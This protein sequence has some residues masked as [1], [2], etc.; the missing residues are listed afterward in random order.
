MMEAVRSALLELEDAHREDRDGGYALA[1]EMCTLRSSLSESESNEWSQVLLDRVTNGSSRAWGVALEAMA[2]CGTA[3]DAAALANIVRMRNIDAAR[4][5]QIAHTLLRLHFHDE[6]LVALVAEAARARR[7]LGLPNLAA[8]LAADPTVAGLAAES[9]HAAISA[10][11]SDYMERY[12]P[13]FAYAA[14]EGG[15]S[16]IVVLVAAL[17]DIDVR[18]AG[19]FARF[20]VAY[21]KKPFV[22][23]KI[24]LEAAREIEHALAAYL[25]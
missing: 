19:L 11:G 21:L 25:Q 24:D 2:R 13:P 8:L 16:P 15:A 7:P 3:S 18:E 20:L 10:E 17:A 22:Q 5:D 9:V 1:N 23:K 14:V 4:A 12:I 6:D